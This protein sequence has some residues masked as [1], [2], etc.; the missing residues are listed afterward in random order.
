MLP[1]SIETAMEPLLKAD[2][3]PSQPQEHGHVSMTFIEPENRQGQSVKRP[4]KYPLSTETTAEST[5]EAITHHTTF[6]PPMWQPGAWPMPPHFP[7]GFPGW[8]GWPPYFMPPYGPYGPPLDPMSNVSSDYPQFSTVPMSTT[9]PAHSL[10]AQPAHSLSTQPSHSS[11][12]LSAQSSRHRDWRHR[13]AEQEDQ[14]RVA[15]GEPPKKRHKKPGQYRYICT[16]CQKQKCAETG[17]TQVKGRWYCPSIGITVDEW[18][19]RMNI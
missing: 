16:T 8:Y 15:R 9:Q 18:K 5:S 14:E 13:K 11:L 3:R 17:H 1:E 4:R 19:E 10:S 7:P 6:A 12:T 2:K